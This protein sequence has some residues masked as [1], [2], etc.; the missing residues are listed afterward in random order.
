M[1]NDGVCGECGASNVPVAH[2]CSQC[3]H[4]LDASPQTVGRVAHP[5]PTAVPEGYRKCGLAADLYY[6]IGSAW[7]GSRLLGTEN[8]G[9]SIFN[10]G[11]SLKEVELKVQGLDSSGDAL[12][13]FRQKLTELPRRAEMSFEVPSYE[14]NEPPADIQ[15]DL[16]SAAYC[17]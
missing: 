5:S 4:P 15:V 9:I 14:I 8:L 17:Q 11:Y 13:E 12:F 6:R 7:G 1:G 2:F 16:V 10:G 3:G